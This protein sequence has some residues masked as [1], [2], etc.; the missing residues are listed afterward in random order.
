MNTFEVKWST[1]KTTVYESVK[2]EEQFREGM[3]GHPVRLPDGVIFRALEAAHA[4]QAGKVQESNLR[5]HQDG[6]GGGKTAEASSG[7]RPVESRE[8]PKAV[9]KVEVTKHTAKAKK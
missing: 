4:A 6:D 3:F 9:P 1:G 7:D 5:E 8:V 2:S